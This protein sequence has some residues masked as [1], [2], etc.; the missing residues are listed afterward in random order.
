MLVLD[1]GTVD[2]DLHLLGDPADPATCLARH[3]RLLERTLGAGV[4]HLVVDTYVSSDAIPRAGPF[5][6]VVLRCEPGD[7]DCA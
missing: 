4:Y 7:P 2:V 6:L 3:D 1:R 5:L